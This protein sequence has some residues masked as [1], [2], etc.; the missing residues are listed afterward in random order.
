M[1]KFSPPSADFWSLWQTRGHSAVHSQNAVCVLAQSRAV[2]AGAD[3][4]TGLVFAGLVIAGSGDWI[5]SGISQSIILA[6]EQTVPLPLA[7]LLHLHLHFTHN[8]YSISGDY[9]FKHFSTHYNVLR[10]R[11]G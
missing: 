4:E 3:R 8:S 2:V 6:I 11:P 1:E 10:D 7:A 9:S 5:S